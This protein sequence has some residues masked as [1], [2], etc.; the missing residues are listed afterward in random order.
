MRLIAIR[1]ALAGRL[2]LVRYFIESRGVPVNAITREEMPA[3]ETTH[4]MGVKVA[5]LSTPLIGAL[6]FQQ[7]KVANYL[8]ARMKKEE[9]RCLVE[10]HHADIHLLTTSSETAADVAKR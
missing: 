8:L 6:D 9:V 3:I 10:K 7:E 5:L 4:N 2:D 1:A